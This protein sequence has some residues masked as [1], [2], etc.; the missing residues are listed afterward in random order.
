MTNRQRLTKDCDDLWRRI[1]K[2][3]YKGRCGICG[4]VGKDPHHIAR[5]N[6]QMRWLILNGIWLCRKCHDHDHEH[7]MNIKISAKIGL[8]LFVHL[9][10]L[11]QEVKGYK[12]W[13]LLMVK[14][15]LQI[16]LKRI[17]T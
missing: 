7:Q 8:D 1:I 17:K 14:A 2:L 3:K 5:K 6:G 16:E 12:E 10:E 9:Y 15:G 11:G 13:E 4:G